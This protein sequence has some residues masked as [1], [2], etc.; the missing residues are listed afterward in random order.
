MGGAYPLASVRVFCLSARCSCKS[1]QERD[2][3][4]LSYFPIAATSTSQPGSRTCETVDSTRSPAVDS[5]SRSPA[6]IVQN[7]SPAR[8]VKKIPFVVSIYGTGSGGN[9]AQGASDEGAHFRTTHLSMDRETNV[10]FAHCSL[11][12][13]PPGQARRRARAYLGDDLGL[14]EERGARATRRGARTSCP[15]RDEKK[16]AG[17]RF[18]P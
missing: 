5:S 8:K 6:S 15:T 13:K 3:R 14:A 18:T 2:A 4:S 1:C 11:L 17:E 16:S 10:T 7:C 9:V 12:V